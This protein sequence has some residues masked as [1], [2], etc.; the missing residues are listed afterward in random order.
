MKGIVDNHMNPVMNFCGFR[1]NTAKGQ[2][3]VF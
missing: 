1:L 3:N 2:S